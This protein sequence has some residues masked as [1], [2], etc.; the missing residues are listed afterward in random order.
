MKRAIEHNASASRFEW[1]E[2]GHL[3]VLEYVLSGSTMDITHTSVPPEAGGRGIAADLA[4]AALDTARENGW[5]VV[6]SCSYVAVHIRRHK[7]YQDLLA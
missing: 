6:P 7:Q 3:C 1:T 4:N 2:D 5:R